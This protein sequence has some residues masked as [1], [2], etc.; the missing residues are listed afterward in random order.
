MI[1]VR[2]IIE[3]LDEML[4]RANSTLLSVGG[5]GGLTRAI[6]EMVAGP[7]AFV[8]PSAD[9]AGSNTAGTGVVRQ[10]V[11]YQFSVITGF[12]IEGDEEAALDEID[13]IARQAVGEALIGWQ[14]PDAQTPIV[15]VGGRMVSYDIDNRR[16]FWG[17]DYAADYYER[18]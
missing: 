11:T 2:P 6:D 13:R 12:V 8:V 3:R 5:I 1:S 7:C 10:R 17:G 18:V 4:V 9:R 14:P 16:V 15:Y